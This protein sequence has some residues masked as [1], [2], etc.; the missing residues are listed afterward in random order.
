MY[1]RFLGGR[2]RGTSRLPARHQYLMRLHWK[3]QGV[4]SL[5]GQNAG[6]L[7][8]W[9][10]RVDNLN[11]GSSFGVCCFPPFIC[12]EQ[13]R[14]PN[15]HSFPLWAG[16]HLAVFSREETSAQ[17]E[18][19]SLGSLD[20]QNKRYLRDISCLVKESRE[21]GTENQFVTGVKCSSTTPKLCQKKKKTTHFLQSFYLHSRKP[22]AEVR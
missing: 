18:A 11:Q 6:A 8:P 21:P 7:F 22:P 14:N 4:G 3:G 19:E 20:H 16:N 2:N 5:Q 9:K 12:P 13:R 1:K 10:T 17:R 15:T